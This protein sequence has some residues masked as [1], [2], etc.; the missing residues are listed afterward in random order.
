VDAD[1]L[2]GGEGRERRSELDD[3]APLAPDTAR[4]LACDASIVSMLEAEG[5]VL[6]VGRKTRA[7][8][9]ALRSALQT[10]DRGCRF[11]GCGNH[12]FLDAH[13]VRHWAQ[14]GET[15]LDNLV[16]LCARHHRLLHEGGFGLKRLPGGRLCFWRPDG[17]VIPDSPVTP[18]SEQS[19]LS[20]RN[21]SAGVEVES[22]ELLTG[23][24]GWT[25]GWPSTR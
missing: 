21:R 16:Q 5:S 20:D 13:H 22:A 1:T 4:R 12:R 23:T 2:S 15:N 10:R 18:P 6:S 3:G 14:G 9:P 19:A 8:P 11:P 25:S 7:I 24:G 17:T